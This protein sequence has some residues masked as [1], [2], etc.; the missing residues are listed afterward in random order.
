MQII[1]DILY[2]VFMI[3][4]IFKFLYKQSYFV[5]CTHL[6]VYLAGVGGDTDDR[7]LCSNLVPNYA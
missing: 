5:L 6:I 1:W 4:A 7:K 3:H 2:N